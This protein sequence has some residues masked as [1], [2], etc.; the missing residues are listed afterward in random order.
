[1]IEIREIEVRVEAMLV[2]H[3]ELRSVLWLQVFIKP[4]RHVLVIVRKAKEQW[5]NESG[6]VVLVEEV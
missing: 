5:R 6:T 1:M 3:S 4:F 2:T